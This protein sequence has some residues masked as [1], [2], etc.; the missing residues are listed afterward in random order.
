MTTEPLSSPL[1]QSLIG[2]EEVA[3]FFSNEAELRAMLQVEEALAGAE[4]EVGLIENAAAS[5][6]SEACRSFQPD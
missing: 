2:D 5:R 6:I 4:A 3:A 1:L